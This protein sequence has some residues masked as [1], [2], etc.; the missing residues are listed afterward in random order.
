MLSIPHTS[1]AEKEG[2]A[3]GG[4]THPGGRCHAA[5]ASLVVLR[6]MKG[7]E[8]D[9]E[10]QSRIGIR[11]HCEPHRR[12]LRKTGVLRLGGAGPRMGSAV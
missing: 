4:A 7:I 12:R 9:L 2:E 8:V 5:R 3:K 1:S 11:R 10:F 6:L